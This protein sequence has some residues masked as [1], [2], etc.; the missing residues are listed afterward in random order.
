MAGADAK[1]SRCTVLGRRGGAVQSNGGIGTSSGL[2]RDYPFACRYARK[3]PG[4]HAWVL[5]LQYL[6]QSK[7]GVE[8]QPILREIPHY[9]PIANAVQ[10]VAAG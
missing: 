10:I 3:G 5:V 1:Y 2:Q 6:T 9:V 7:Q 4:L 8:H